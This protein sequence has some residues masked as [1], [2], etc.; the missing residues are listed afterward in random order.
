MEKVQ[1]CQRSILEVSA[2][3]DFSPSLTYNFAPLTG[4]IAALRRIQSDYDEIQFESAQCPDSGDS[5]VH[6]AAWLSEGESDPSLS[7]KQSTAA[8]QGNAESH[9][10][11]KCAAGTGQDLLNFALGYGAEIDLQNKR[12]ESPLH[13]AIKR[14]HLAMVRHKGLDCRYM[15]IC[16]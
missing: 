6:V 16:L 11:E 8:A 5:I 12:G 7:E 9:Q 1:F 4:N 14:N 10:T 13:V 2:Y 3:C 15:V